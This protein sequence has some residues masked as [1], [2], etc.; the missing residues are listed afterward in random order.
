MLNAPG[1]KKAVLHTISR[2]Q[3]ELQRAQLAL[4]AIS[5][6]ATQL[7]R[8]PL[9]T[10]PEPK[11]WVAGAAG[12]MAVALSASLAITDITTPAPN[13]PIAMTGFDAASDEFAPFSIS[14]VVVAIPDTGAEYQELA[15]EL[16]LAVGAESAIVPAAAKAIDADA[17]VELIALLDAFLPLAETHEL[18]VDAGLL[19]DLQ[20]QAERL[21]L[22]LPITIQIPGDDSALSLNT[23]Y[24]EYDAAAIVDG[25]TG[26]AEAWSETLAAATSIERT[27]PAS[28]AHQRYAPAS[29]SAART[30]IPTTAS[31]VQNLA[32]AIE[33]WLS[34]EEQAARDAEL[35][36]IADLRAR[37][38]QL[39]RSH[40]NG[41]LPSEALCTIPFSTR[42]TMRCDVIPS[43]VQLNYAFRQQFGR[44]LQVNSGYRSGGNGRSNHGWGLAI[45]LGGGIQRF[46]TAEFRWM[47]ANAYRFGWGHAF[48]AR[49][50][51][52]NPEPWHWEAMSEIRELTGSWR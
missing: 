26:A 9:P 1:I 7:P 6:S 37:M 12:I 11:P 51:G 44:D 34:D 29:R 46:G 33:T 27:A 31:E 49:P 39:S 17:V 35:Q 14:D 21:G 28:R 47:D 3:S 42:F 4:K 40:G 50:G 15:A 30:G 2:T 8:I 45:D 19:A 41:R 22:V 43:L 48:W 5:F 36:R 38:V 52:I 24:L 10:L 20:L 25:L 18:P 13:Q 32:Q 16:G 23:I